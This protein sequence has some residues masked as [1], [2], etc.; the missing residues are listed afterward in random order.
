M[1]RVLIPAFVVFA[2]GPAY[3]QTLTALGPPIAGTPWSIVVKNDLADYC[4]VHP[5]VMLRST[6]ELVAPS[7][8]YQSDAL[9]TLAPG[10]DTTLSIDIPAMGPGSQGSCL[11]YFRGGMHAA[12]RI[13]IGAPATTFPALHVALENIASGYGSHS[14]SYEFESSRVFLLNS[15]S[16]SHILSPQD[17]VRVFAPG[18]DSALVEMSIAGTQ[19]EPGKGVSMS[20][21]LSGLPP[22]AYTIA[23]EMLDPVVG[24]IERRFGLHPLTDRADLHFPAGHVVP[25]NGEIPA[26]ILAGV[27]T[28][29]G[30][31]D[32]AL[33]LGKD[34]GT[35]PLGHGLT[36]PLARD[37]FV[38][39][40]L[41]SNLFQSL[42]NG[43]GRL[44]EAPAPCFCYGYDYFQSPKILIHHPDLPIF[45]GLTLRAAAVVIAPTGIAIAVTQAEDVQFE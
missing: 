43:Q 4:A 25:D 24:L 38:M 18:S 34:L 5:L 3:A 21:P 15:S 14:F 17:R 7:Y 11:L 29:D 8:T 30:N 16:E 28:L 35:T 9:K 19:I 41:S 22:A 6:G 32:Y 40:S 23:I 33:M 13:D 39:Q 42:R 37:V 20:L 1:R 10:E 2:V 12:K 31:P 36:L 27:K 45:K 26:H 44:Q